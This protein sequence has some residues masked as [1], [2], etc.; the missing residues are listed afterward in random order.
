MLCTARAHAE[1]VRRHREALT[2]EQR[3]MRAY[4][5][6]S[7]NWERWFTLEHKE[8]RRQGVHVDHDVPPPP[9]E[10]LLHEE[11]EETA[12]QTALELVLQHAL[13]ASR[14]EEEAQWDGMERA[15]AL[16][17]AGDSVHAPLFF[18]AS[19]TAAAA[20]RQ[21]QAGTGAHANAEALAASTHLA[22]GVLH[23]DRR[24]S[25]VGERAS[26]PLRRDAGGGGG[27]P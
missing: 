14:I 27:P 19:A 18:P 25:R 2:P 13:E 12:Y 23:V 16:S 11:D 15:L 6:D 24:V 8:E 3:Q 1:E 21:A 9:H 7:P 20:R 26:G 10:V 17:A 22:G 5:P 4:M